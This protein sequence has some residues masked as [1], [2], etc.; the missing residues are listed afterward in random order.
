METDF[1]YGTFWDKKRIVSKPPGLAQAAPLVK[2]L[3]PYY[4]QISRLYR[5][6]K[7]SK[8]AKVGRYDVYHEPNYL[9]LRFSGP[10][11]ITVHDLSWIRYP[12]THP[13][14]RVLMMN[15]YFDKALRQASAL[16][17]DAE[18]VRQEIIDTFGVSPEK[19]TAIPLGVESIFR[20]RAESETQDTLRTHGLVHKSY[21]LTVGTLEP[22]KNLSLAIRAYGALPD[23]IR[24]RF[25]LVVIGMTGWHSTEIERLIAPLQ[26]AGY[27]RQLG[28]VT[29]D[30]LATIMAGATTLIYPSI[31]E[32]FGLPPLE[33]MASGTPVIC[34]NVSTLPEVVGDTGILIDPNDSEKLRIQLE[35]ITS[36]QHLCHDLAVRARKRS[37]SFTWAHCAQQ[38]LNVYKSVAI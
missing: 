22:R 21:F 30:D 31:Y 14:E 18:F 32:G 10:T 2:R 1:F 26:R 4:T 38:T 20:P 3:T 11:V 35:A 17:T 7:F 19:I 6:Y 8:Q 13:A 24:K 23:S 16:I 33:A 29:R 5:Q 36:D 28:Y 15:R 34:S 9:P 12:E 25:P 27:I 37:L